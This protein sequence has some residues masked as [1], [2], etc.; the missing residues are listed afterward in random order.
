VVT[1]ADETLRAVVSRM[2]GH[3][4]DKMPVVDRDDPGRIVG[5]ISL[6]MLLAGR[7]KDLQEARDSERVLRL[8]V[9]RPRWLGPAPSRHETQ[10]EAGT[11][12]G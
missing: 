10:S 8:R 6:T 7:V 3:E 2:A 9:V 12:A 4:V 1:H 11:G 5:I